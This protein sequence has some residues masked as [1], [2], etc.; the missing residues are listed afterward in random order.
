[1]AKNR[2]LLAENFKEVLGDKS[3]LFNFSQ[4]KQAMD[5]WLYTHFGGAVTDEH[6]KCLFRPA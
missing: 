2:K 5:S 4:G 1:M 6:L 3:Q